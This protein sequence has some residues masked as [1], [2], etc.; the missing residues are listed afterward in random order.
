[1]Q[2]PVLYRADGTSEKV[3]PV[4]HSWTLEELYG[5]LKCDMIELVHL[6]SQMVMVI[7]E[8]GKFKDAP[9]VNLEATKM[10]H[11]SKSI[12]PDDVIVG[13]ALVTP[14]KLMD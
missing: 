8:E 4:G 6:D 1:M 9:Q 7:D 5:H 3:S 2:T 12:S 11:L 14:S 10:A 13:N